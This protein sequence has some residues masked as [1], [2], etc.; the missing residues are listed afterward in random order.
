M[1]SW[2]DACLVPTPNGDRSDFRAR[3][4]K[5]KRERSR[6]AFIAAAGRL[7]A[8]R[9]WQGTRLEDIAREAGLG[10][11]T[12]YNHFPS[13][14]VLVATVYAPLMQPL[15]DHAQ[16][17]LAQARPAPEALRRHIHELVGIA[18]AHR[19]L[20]IPF[21]EAVTE[22]TLRAGGPPVRDDDPRRIVPLTTP[23]IQLVETGQQRGELRPYPAAEDVGPFITNAALLRVL[24]H[25]HESAEDTTA[26]VLTFLLCAM[27]LVTRVEARV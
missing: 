17:D 2:G 12:V 3:A 25:P 9:G 18:R 20:T 24:T 27:G 8:Q 4:G 26:L 15:F 5:T 21:L 22:A 13:K 23:L 14:L 1:T 7:F 11:A 10:A 6:A 19:A 16:D